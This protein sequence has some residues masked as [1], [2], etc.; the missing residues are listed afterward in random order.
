M[1]KTAHVHVHVQKSA[2][3]HVALLQAIDKL[4]DKTEVLLID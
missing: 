3:C 1:Y 4:F 2:E